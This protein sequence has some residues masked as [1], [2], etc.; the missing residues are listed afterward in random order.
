MKNRSI[1]NI[2]EMHFDRE[3]HA[4]G[5]MKFQIVWECPVWGQ[6][7]EEEAEEKGVTSKYYSME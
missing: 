3:H 6:K 1:Q 7:K 5:K 4:P 2:K